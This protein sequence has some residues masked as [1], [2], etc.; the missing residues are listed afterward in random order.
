[1]SPGNLRL[2]ILIAAMFALR[3][4][5]MAV[6]NNSTAA[7]V[8]SARSIPSPQPPHL[9]SDALSLAIPLLLMAYY[10][11]VWLAVGREPKLGIVNV[12]YEPPKGM[13][14]AEARFAMIGGTDRKTTAAVL[15]NMASEKIIRIVPVGDEYDITR[16][17]D[18]AP[19][20]IPTEEERA[21][22]VLFPRDAANPQ[23]P[24]RRVNPKDATLMIQF[25]SQIYEALDKRL[26][27]KYF[28][29]NLGWCVLGFMFSL[30][31]A[32]ALLTRYS[33]HDAPFL[34][35]WFFL[36]TGGFGV[37]IATN[38][39]PLFKDWVR[40]ELSAFN[41][42]RSF[43]GLPV[44]MA[45]VL[46]VIYLIAA[47]TSWAYGEMIAVLLAMNIVWGVLLKSTTVEGVEVKRQLAGFKEYLVS[48][49]RDRLDKL[50]DPSQPPVLMDDFFAY[51]IALDVK[52]GWGDRLENSL[53]G[54]ATWR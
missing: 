39:V 41:A 48:V 2:T 43:L 8:F 29:R 38:L 11:V 31:C 35:F 7:V 21:F 22:E 54:V 24:T 3:A 27:G 23:G 33:S 51:A 15:A 13:S 52:E 5:A 10:F 47:K 37:M 44:F 40:G 12:C 32:L 34:V 42:A 36:F 25:S 26:R 9:L 46:F 45:P 17:M 16:L 50:N 28:R 53:F 30:V 6:M 49:E 14:P 19:K 4:S 18:A 20:N 1:M